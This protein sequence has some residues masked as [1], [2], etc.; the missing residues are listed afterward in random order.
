[1]PTTELGEHKKEEDPG[2]VLTL[3]AGVLTQCCTCWPF[4]MAL[5]RRRT[6]RQAQPSPAPHS[7]RLPPRRLSPPSCSEPSSS[8]TRWRVSLLPRVCATARGI[9]F[10]GIRFSRP[11]PKIEVQNT[12]RMAAL[13]LVAWRYRFRMLAE[14]VCGHGCNL[15]SCAAGIYYD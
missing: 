6:R 2:G 9:R 7:P 12:T 14:A 4:G 11:C 13:S 15:Y 5:C 10:H 8:A 3:R 1:M